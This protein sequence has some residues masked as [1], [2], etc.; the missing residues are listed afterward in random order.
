MTHSTDKAPVLN[1][2]AAVA[3]A[4][5]RDKVV[6]ELNRPLSK[7]VVVVQHSSLGLHLAGAQPKPLLLDALL[8]TDYM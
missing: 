3:V 4:I 7:A 1:K 6:A 8:S 5:S 2:M